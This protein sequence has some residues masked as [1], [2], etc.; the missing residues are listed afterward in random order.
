M[1]I[2]KKKNTKRKKRIGKR[3]FRYWVVAT[4]AVG[5]LIAYSIGSDRTVNLAMAK[6]EKSVIA[7]AVDENKSITKRFDIPAGTLDDVLK[8]FEKE[9][10]WRV[11]LPNYEAKTIGSK[12][13]SGNF[14]E[15]QALV[16][17]LLETG[18]TYSF[19]A[20]KTVA[21]RVLGPNETVEVV[22]E[23]QTIASPKYTEPLRNIPQTVNVIKKETIEE[24][25]A[26]T[27][28]DVL[29]NVPGLTINAGEGGAV[30]GDNIN[31]RGF[32]ARNDIFVDGARDLS[33]Q[34]RD[35]FS[36]E[37]VEV[38][39]GPS[40]SFT[41]RG[42][43]GGTVNLVSKT[44]GFRPFYNFDL[45]AGTDKTK[46]ITTDVNLPLARLGLGEQTA[47]R[48]NF[49][50]HDSTVAGR[51][52]VENDRWGIAPTL[53]F[54]VGKKSFFTLGFLHIGQDNVA[55]YGIPWVPATN[56]ALADFR[57][58]PAPVSRGTFYGFKDRDNEILKSNLATIAINH[59]FSDALSLRNQFRFGRSTRDSIAT[60]PRFANTNSTAINREMRSWLTTDETYDN[61]TDFSA[62][63]KTGIFEHSLVTG[64][65]FIREKNLRYIRSAANSPTTLLN[66]NPFDVF[67]GVFAANSLPGDITATTQ[68]IYLLD[69]IKLHPKFDLSGSLRYD[70]Y[71]AEGFLPPTVNLTPTV[72][73]GTTRAAISKKDDLWNYR[74]GAVYKPFEIGSIYASYGTA[75]NPSLSGLAYDNATVLTLD[76]EETETYEFGTKWDLLERR[77]LLTAAVFR[78]EKTNARTPGI[79]GEVQILD[80]RQR[81]DGIELGITG[82]ITRNWSILTGYTLLDSKV[83]E[84]NAN[85]AVAGNPA[86]SLE[87][88]KRLI[89]TPRNSFN[90]W[91]TYS[92]PFKLNIG[93]GARFVDK[94]FGNSINTRFVE[95]YW[96]VDATASYQVTKNIEFRVN[97]SNLTDKFYFDRLTGGHVVPGAGRS[98]LFTTAFKF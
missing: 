43:T 23:N 84:S 88:G 50:A 94:R 74:V 30:G 80:G 87:I 16:Q 67:T 72:I 42:S 83:I 93:G 37:Q 65:E 57:D 91:S 27:L 92:F 68:S 12:G 11:I 86:T 19:T 38:V 70:R 98:V 76:P 31:L 45:T 34:S 96:L 63:F 1:S 40:S 77:I 47:F 6:E 7:E 13:V 29:R 44:P 10:G 26:T 22:S 79:N 56:N 18:F 69:T 36:L 52:I 58:K 85:L 90:L 62:K 64:A 2:N 71:N 61:Q 3:G 41:G 24:Q 33:P 48:L 15:E 53:S 97:G 14:T 25:G 46:R 17:I 60:P 81:V 4:T 28:R 59:T 95:S 32:S 66:P 5:V 49:M 35:P 8:T 73:L 20:P 54:A 21:L 55:D 82:N 9:T 51:E 39:K 89:N 75:V 78:I